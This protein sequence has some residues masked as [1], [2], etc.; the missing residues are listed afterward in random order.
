MKNRGFFRGVFLVAAL[1]DLVLGLVFFFLYPWVYEYLG[2]PCP[3][4][5][6]TFT[7]PPPS[8]SSRASCITWC[9]GTW[10]ETL[11]WSWWE[12]S[13]KAVYSGVAFYHWGMGDPAP[14]HLRTLRVPGRH[15]PGHVP[16]LPEGGQED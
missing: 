3:P 1:Y 4:S 12:P 5:Q 8:C 13:T 7:L 15:L 2:S 16:L 10:S 6:P 14:S 11:T 9:T